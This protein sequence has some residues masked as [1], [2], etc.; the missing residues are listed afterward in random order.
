MEYTCEIISDYKIIKVK[1][2]GDLII[3]ESASL[4]KKMRR[5]ARRMNY[6]ILF[7]L[8]QIKNR[9]TNAEN[10][11]WYANRRDI[12]DSSFKYIPIA[13]LINKNYDS[14]F[15]TFENYCSNNGI[16]LR[17]FEEKEKAI[18]WLKPL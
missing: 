12:I 4:G 1:V 10:Y 7:D 3:K 5:L 2:F 9:I 11:A 6:S 13:Y 16:L 18:E 14:V 15:N 8:T 17:I